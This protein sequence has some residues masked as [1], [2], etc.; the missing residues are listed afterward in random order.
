LGEGRTAGT[1]QHEQVTLG[2][3]RAKEGANDQPCSLWV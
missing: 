1:H 2:I 3:R